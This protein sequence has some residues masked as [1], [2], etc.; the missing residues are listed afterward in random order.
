MINC[1][2]EQLISKGKGLPY[3]L[4]EIKKWC[5]VAGRSGG[6]VGSSKKENIRKI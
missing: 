3:S 2:E 4:T 5:K 1:L 6:V